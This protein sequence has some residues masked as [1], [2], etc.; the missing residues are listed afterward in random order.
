MPYTKVLSI[1][2]EYQATEKSNLKKNRAAI[3]TGLKY[4]RNQEYQATQQGTLK[5]QKQSKN[6]AQAVNV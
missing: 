5:K 4:S 2:C 3:H 6:K 1:Q